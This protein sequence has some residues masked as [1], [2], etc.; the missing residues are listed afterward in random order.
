MFARRIG[1][2]LRL[3][4][5]DIPNFGFPLSFAKT[6]IVPPPHTRILCIQCLSPLHI[7]LAAVDQQ[8]GNVILLIA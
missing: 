7:L 6:S 4:E 8:Q 3:Q 2:W 1:T 5:G